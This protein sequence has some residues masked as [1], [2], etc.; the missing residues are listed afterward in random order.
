[1][2]L[3]VVSSVIHR[4]LARCGLLFM[5][6]WVAGGCAPDSGPVLM[7]TVPA[8]GI[9]TLDGKPLAAAIVTFTPLEEGMGPECTGTSDA[10]GK[11]SLKQVR[12]SEG[13]PVG[14]FKVAV[15]RYVKADGSAIALAEGEFPA[16]VGATESL[17]AKYSSPTDTELTASV[18]GPTE[19]LKIELK[20]K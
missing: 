9:V 6:V 16:N 1:M 15:N 7:P 10:E 18:T 3:V 5:L 11:F 13:A 4:G 8:S 12:G 20:S 2:S 19:N 17:P 14:Q